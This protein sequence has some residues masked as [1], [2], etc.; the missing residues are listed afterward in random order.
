MRCGCQCTTNRLKGAIRR[1]AVF[2][3]STSLRPVLKVGNIYSKLSVG[4]S[5]CRR[6]GETFFAFYAPKN[7]GPGQLDTI[8]PSKTV[9][10]GKLGATVPK[11]TKRSNCLKQSKTSASAIKLQCLKTPSSMDI[12]GSTLVRNIS[13]ASESI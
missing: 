11:S 5:D 7:A 4:A 3:P 9:F 2:R 8:G 12:D 10:Q 1:L 6:G 13:K